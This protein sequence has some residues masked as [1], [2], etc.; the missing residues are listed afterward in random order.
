[1]GVGVAAVL[2][3]ARERQNQ[4]PP[5]EAQNWVEFVVSRPAGSVSDTDA[6]LLYDIWKAA[7][8]GSR[9]FAPPQGSD[10]GKIM[11]LKAKGLIAGFGDRLE[12]TQK[13]RKVVVE[14]VT[15][16]PNAFSKQSEMA[17]SE[18]KRAASKRPIQS[19]V[20]KQVRAAK[21]SPP[22]NLKKARSGNAD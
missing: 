11:A 3:F 19:L 22:Y 1:M 8:P 20:K 12:L 10:P 21:E 15:H 6:S 16:E 7:P 17:Y 4:K 9:T 18:I 13:G 2:L 14:M 5:A